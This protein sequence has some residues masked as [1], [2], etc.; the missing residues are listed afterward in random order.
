MIYISLRD[1][2]RDDLSVFIP[3]TCIFHFLFIEVNYGKSIIGIIYRPN[4]APKADLDIFAN[5]LNGI[6]DIVNTERK[7]SIIMGDMNIDLPKIDVHQKTNDYLSLFSCSF[8]PTITLHTR[9][10]CNSATLIDHI[11]K[12]RTTT[13]K[14]GIIITD[15][16]DHFGIFYISSENKSVSNKRDT[17]R[18]VRYFSNANY[19]NFRSMLQNTNFDNVLLAN[20]TNEAYNILIKLYMIAFCRILSAAYR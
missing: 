2:F 15:V 12:N 11:H 8:S 19:E 14:S 9:L 7:H 3:H 18:L 1:K 6:L 4:T 10:S 17:K 5:T 20:C 13:T 16:A